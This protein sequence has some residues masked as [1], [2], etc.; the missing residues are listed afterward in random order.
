MNINTVT[1][2]Q[3][4]AIYT[5]RISDEQ[6]LRTGQKQQLQFGGAQIREQHLTSIALMN[7]NTVTPAQ[8]GAIYTFRISD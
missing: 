1:P 5:F 6:S 8:M 3:M 4:G 2:A 7:I